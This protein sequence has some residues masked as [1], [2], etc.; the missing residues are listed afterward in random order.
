[1]KKTL[2]MIILAL[3]ILFIGA[4][5]M[6][7]IVEE[8]VVNTERGCHIA[9]YLLINPNKYSIMHSDEILTKQRSQ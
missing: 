4:C 1:M 7:E 5:V 9:P 2:F 8:P 3:S 6:Q